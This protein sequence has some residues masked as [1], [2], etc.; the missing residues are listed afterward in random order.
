MDDQDEWFE[1]VWEFREETLYPRLF[2][3]KSKNG[4]FTLS[5]EFFRDRFGESQI[6]PRWTSHG[7]LVFPPTEQE[8][9]WRYVTSGLSN[10]WEVDT[11]DPDSWSGVGVEFVVASAREERWALNVAQVVLAY[12]LLLAAGRFG[13]NPS[14]IGPYHRI[15]LGGPIDGGNSALTHLFVC[16]APIAPDDLRL[17]SG[18]F[19]LLQ[20]V[21]VTE[22]E[23][24]FARERGGEQ[25][26]ERLTARSTF[27]VT[28]P[29]RSSVV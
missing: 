22:A 5:F 17:E 20:L 27:P 1:R 25:L 9:S 2:G 10:E 16:P 6:D 11:P 18:R 12:Q 29:S 15:P 13:D 14:L 8:S 24:Q 21:G 28:N 4:I 26:M 23:I 3:T 7:V 19:S